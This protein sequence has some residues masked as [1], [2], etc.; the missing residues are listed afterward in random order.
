[1]QSHR[2]APKHAFPDIELFLNACLGAFLFLW[3]CLRSFKNFLLAN[4]HQSTNDIETIPAIGDDDTNGRTC[5]RMRT[6]GGQEVW[7]SY[8][9]MCQSHLFDINQ[10]NHISCNTRVRPMTSNLYLCGTIKLACRP[11]KLI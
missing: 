1:M 3:P 9:D 4:C 10:I 8:L 2:K 11:L 7:S 5:C 6:T